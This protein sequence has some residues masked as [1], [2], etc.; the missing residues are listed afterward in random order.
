MRGV[1]HLL[2]SERQFRVMLRAELRKRLLEERGVYVTE[3]CDT[4]GQLPGPVRYTRKDD[5][6]VWCSRACRDG[7]NAA[8]PGK[9]RGCGASLEGKRKGS[10]WCGEP[11]RRMAGY[12]HKP[13]NKI[14]PRIDL[15]NKGLADAKMASL[16]VHP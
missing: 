3:A 8:T 9:C 16:V 14:N 13:N 1:E 10:K 11:C 4:C 2:H 6:G 7:Q 12:Q 15:E 5:P